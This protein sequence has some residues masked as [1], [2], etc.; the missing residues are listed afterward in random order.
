MNRE[1]QIKT[2]RETQQWD[3]V[4]IGGGATGLGSAL[5]AASRGFK[6]LCIEK[7]IFPKVHPVDLQN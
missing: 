4:I 5:D 3:I 1:D 6:T 7:L 2:I